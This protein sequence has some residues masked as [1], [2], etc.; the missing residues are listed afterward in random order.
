MTIEL[1]WGEDC[2]C[3]KCLPNPPPEQIVIILCPVED[4][5]NEEPTIF[6][7]YVYDDDECWEVDGC[8]CSKCDP[9]P[10]P[11]ITSFTMDMAKGW[12]DDEP[13]IFQKLFNFIIACFKC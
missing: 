9:N 12:P 6:R 2:A 8:A 1:C 5:P 13:F 7:D 4:W 11:P 3:Q 10:P